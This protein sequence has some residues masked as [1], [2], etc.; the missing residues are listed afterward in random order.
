MKRLFLSFFL[1]ATYVAADLQLE[2]VSLVSCPRIGRETIPLFCLYTQVHRHGDRT[3]ASTYTGN[4]YGDDYWPQGLGQLTIVRVCF[5][6]RNKDYISSHN[7]REACKSN[8][9]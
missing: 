5:S 6:V 8:T 7:F 4:P 9:T 1:C 3:P 2:L